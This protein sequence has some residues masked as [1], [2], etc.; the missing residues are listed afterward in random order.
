MFVCSSF[1]RLNTPELRKEVK[2]VQFHPVKMLLFSGESWRDAVKRLQSAE[3]VTWGE[4]GVRVKGYSLDAE[5]K[6][7]RLLGVCAET[8]EEEI[9]KTFLEVGIGEVV[10]I[11]K[12][13]LDSRRLP[14]VTNGTWAL[15]VKILDQDCFRI[16]GRKQE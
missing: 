2:D 3:G 14:G 9:K 12:G 1:A 13:W 4:Y 6:F 11:K 7:I 10:E 16:T 15:R 8:G 5:V